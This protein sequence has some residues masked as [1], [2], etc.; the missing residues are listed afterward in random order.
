MASI[1]TYV[2]GS[3]WW[4]ADSEDDVINPKRRLEGDDFIRD[5]KFFPIWLECVKRV[6]DP[7]KIVVIDSNAPVKPAQNLQAET[8]WIELPFNARHATDHLGK[9]SGWTRSVLASAHYALVSEADYFVYVEQD[10]LLHGSGI[11]EH[12]ISNMT[13]GF[14]FGAGKGTAQPLQQSFFIIRHDKIASFLYN[15]AR[16][17]SRDK[18]LSPEWKFLI[19]TSTVLTS[20][21]NTGLLRGNFIKKVIRAIAKRSLFQSLS[22]GSGRA[23]PIPTQEKYYYAQH[24]TVAELKEAFRES[25]DIT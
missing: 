19:A 5:V 6:A 11:I 14:A 9:W 21:Y 15:L 13:K 18:D 23:R 25:I 4:C 17:N 3:G 16:I 2:I 20:I 10:C 24:C 8:V 1:P 7:Q 22:V 12:C